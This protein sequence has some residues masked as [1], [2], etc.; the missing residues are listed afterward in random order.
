MASE[1][2]SGAKAWGQCY[3]TVGHHFDWLPYAIIFAKYYNTTVLIGHEAKE[4]VVTG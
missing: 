3:C 2:G 4:G 1:W